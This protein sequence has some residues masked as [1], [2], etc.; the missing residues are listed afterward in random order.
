MAYREDKKFFSRRVEVKST[1][2][3][4]HLGHVFPDG[5]APGGQRFCINSAALRFIPVSRLEEEG[6]GTYRKA[7]V[8]EPA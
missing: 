1:H 4:S 6:Y 8:T 7:F 5:P 3:S 2:G